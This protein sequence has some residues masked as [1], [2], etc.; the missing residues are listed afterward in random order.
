MKKREWYGWNLSG[1]FNRILTETKSIGF[2]QLSDARLGALLSTLAATKP[3]YFFLSLV[4]G[5]DYLPHGYWR[6]WIKLTFTSVDGDDQFVVIAK[7]I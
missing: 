1:I 3:D 6:K 2:N 4:W 5:V 7:N